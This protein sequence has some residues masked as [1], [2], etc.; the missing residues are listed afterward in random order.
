MTSLFLVRLLF[1]RSLVT[2]A[3]PSSPGLYIFHAPHLLTNIPL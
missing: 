3:Q 1:R 2:V